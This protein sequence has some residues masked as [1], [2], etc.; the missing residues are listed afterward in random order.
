[1]KIIIDGKEVEVGDPDKTIL[2]VARGID[3]DIPTICYDSSLS[4]FGAC[5]MCLVRLK[6]ENEFVAACSTPVEDGMEIETDT[7]R[8]RELR[9]NNLHLLLAEHEENCKVCEANS[10]CT[11]QDLA[12]RYGINES[13]YELDTEDL[14]VY[15]DNP[16]I[17]MDPNKCILCGR[18]VRTCEELQNTEALSFLNKGFEARI[19]L[20]D[21]PSKGRDPEFSNCKFCG[22]C[23]EECPTGAL[24]YKPSK[25]K[26]RGH[27][28]E[29]IKTTCPHC[30]IGCQIELRVKDNEIMQVGSVSKPGTPN[31][32]GE[33]CLRGRF[34]YGFVNHQDRLTKPLIKKNGD[35]KEASWEEA[36]NHISNKIRK[37]K[38]NHGPKAIAG[39]GSGKCTNEENYLFQKLMRA[40]IG[41][42]NV[43][44]L[45]RICH[46][47]TIKALSSA[48]G[49]GA[50]T[51]SIEEIQD[52]ETLFVIGTNTT[53]NHPVIGNKIR[54]AVEDGANLIVA[55]PRRT[56]L[57]EM[58]D[59]SLNH[60]PGTDLP[61][62]NGLLYIIIKENLYDKKFLSSRLGSFEKLKWNIEKYD[63]QTVQN[64]TEIPAEKI[65]KAARYFASVDKASIYYGM[66]ITQHRNGTDNVSALANLAL[67]TKNVG[68]QGTGINPLRGQNNVQGACDT[69]VLPNYYP[70]YQ[71]IDDPKNRNKFEEAW[72]KNLPTEK[73]LTTIEIFNEIEKSNI[74]ALLLM[75]ENPVYSHPNQE[76]VKKSLKEL[77]L[78]VVQDL[79]LTK[80]AEY[81]DVILPAA[82]F[83]EKEGTF[84][85]TERR[86]QRI[87]KAMNPP[88]KAKPDWKILTELSRKLGYQLNYEEPS[89]IME[90]INDLTP[91]YEGINYVKLEKTGLQWPCNEE[92]PKGSKYLYQEGF[93]NKVLKFQTTNYISPAEKFDSE[94]NFIMITGRTQY[95]P[96]TGTTSKR[97]DP[98]EKHQPDPYVEINEKDAKELGIKEDDEIKISSRN[99]EFNA[100]AKINQE[101]QLGQVFIPIHFRESPANKI[102]NAEVDPESQIPELK[103]TAVKIEKT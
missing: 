89:D 58:A 2:E 21:N 71:E 93:K 57:S 37:I 20:S 6:D 74:K 45:T 49:Y 102:A 53:E 62:I 72:G 56:E 65:V 90:E 15:D 97:S 67:L 94:H 12:Y 84:T 91:I 88:E 25:R 66:G 79:F 33:T 47:P 11:I 100:H 4:T 27:E 54:K 101:V 1:M 34:G 83:A 7:E 42:N 55:D 52:A 28:F 17:E 38:K 43:D 8:I 81:A 32:D 18:C 59:I 30:S 24:T 36:L 46:S 77:D 9:K 16:F 41:T 98:I 26:G 51:N 10:D 86:V 22:H 39:I 29:E 103:L 75:G 87:K 40:V 48:F 73:G 61:L 76:K 35:F 19:G 85:N 70:G 92:N 80:S 31:P 44:H 5:R 14:E 50:M 13:K 82:S 78:L 63:P 95:H 3:I 96:Y 23:V 64:M 99:Q 68:R 69:G 60:Q